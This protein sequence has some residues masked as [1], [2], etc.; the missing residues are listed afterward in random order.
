[1]ANTIDIEHVVCIYIYIYRII[2]SSTSPKS[3][4]RRMLSMKRKVF[5]ATGVTC[6]GEWTEWPRYHGTWGAHCAEIC[7]M[8]SAP[9]LARGEIY[10]VY[11]MISEAFQRCKNIKI[12]SSEVADCM[13]PTLLKL[14]SL[15]VLLRWAEALHIGGTPRPQSLKILGF[16]SEHWWKDVGSGRLD[17]LTFIFAPKN[18]IEFNCMQTMYLVIITVSADNAHEMIMM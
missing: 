4:I 16:A 17:I 18:V 7:L 13:E 15:G 10:P 14:T 3:F 9:R 6:P 12:F 2:Y 5:E 11:Q 1:M 8:R